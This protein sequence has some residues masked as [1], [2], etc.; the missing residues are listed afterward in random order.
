MRITTVSIAIGAAVLL[1]CSERD[2]PA[3]A[4]V[5]Q[6][7]SHRAN[8]TSD[9]WLT[10]WS[11]KPDEGAKLFRGW[12][13]T[14]FPYNTIVGEAPAPS[15]INWW[16]DRIFINN[17][18]TYDRLRDEIAAHPGKL[19]VV[20]DEFDAREDPIVYAGQYCDF[21]KGVLRPDYDPTARF[22]PTGIS[23]WIDGNT[24]WLQ[25]FEIAY[26]T[27]RAGACASIPIAE[28]DFHA[29]TANSTPLQVWEDRVDRWANWALHSA[30]HP[31]P[32]VLGN[33]N[34]DYP[35]TVQDQD[36]GYVAR[37]LEAR[38]WLAANPRISLARYQN[39]HGSNDP[40]VGHPLAWEDGVTLRAEG[41]ALGGYIADEQNYAI[42]WGN[43][44]GS[45]QY[46][47][48]YWQ[49]Q[50][51]INGTRYYSAIGMHAPPSGTGWAEYRIPRGAQSFSSI[52]GLARDDNNPCYGEG[53]GRIKVE[54]VVMWEYDLHGSS[55]STAVQTPSI[56]VPEPGGTLR[57]EVEALN[58]NNSCAQTT[59]GDPHFEPSKMVVSGP[60]IVSSPGTYWWYLSTVGF[61]DGVASIS[62]DAKRQTDAQWTTGVCSGSACSRTY[63]SGDGVYTLLLRANVTTSSGRMQ[64]ITYTV[65]FGLQ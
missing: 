32:F 42:G 57:L 1:G 19:Y 34:L 65:R 55:L 6:G 13:I 18:G 23:E 62:W 36:G 51:W 31:A 63:N 58:G 48:V 56:P 29:T 44:L 59:W 14:L 47:R 50:V 12:P 26:D 17:P 22:S 9:H 38:K 53:R 27:V 49:P 21:V 7:P 37:L 41:L 60:D 16:S 28:W 43:V 15:T 3:T 4:P 2:V 45:M 30:R 20:G 64:F 61:Y 39:Y 33:W 40:Q 11:W 10:A 52:F 25:A 24:G 35:Q 8:L 46:D 54:G 5:V